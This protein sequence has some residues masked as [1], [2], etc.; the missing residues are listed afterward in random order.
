MNPKRYIRF[1]GIDVA[2]RAHVARIIDRDGNT[3]AK[4]KSFRNDNEGYRQLLQR[5][6]DAGG[7]RKVLVGMEATGHYWLS[8]HD[9]LTRQGYSVVVLNPIQTAQQAKKGIRTAKTDKIDTEPI[10]VLLKNGEYRPGLIPGELA[11]TCRQLTRLRYALIGHGARIKRQLW[12]RI[13][14]VWPEYE[15]IFSDPFAATGRHLLKVAP[16]PQDVLAIP[17][18][19][20]A[21][22]LRRVSRGKHAAGKACQVRHAAEQSVGMLRGLDGARIGIRM[23]LS[24]LEALRPIRK[25]LEAQ[26]QQVAQKLPPYIL[27]L[28]GA[29]VIKATSLFGETDPITSFR[30]ADQLV[31]FAGLD[32]GAWQTGQYKAP[33]R[34]ISKRG[35]PYLRKTL[36]YMAYRAIYEEGELRDYWLRKRSQGL[37]HL[38]AITATA[39]K[40][41]RVSWRILTDQ[42]AYVPQGPPATHLPVGKS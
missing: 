5:L 11:F 41:C 34:H 10:A 20:L 17:P 18:D 33:E 37:K 29:D 35:C 21:D 16:V 27:T 14:P 2:K 12:S 42:R 25:D 6:A 4:P 22:M 32:L 26:I 13:H 8:L 23:L 28:P 1:C 40:L 7:P 3:V 9:Y 31:A 36:W 19:A 15:V 38:S 39:I 30:T 24:C